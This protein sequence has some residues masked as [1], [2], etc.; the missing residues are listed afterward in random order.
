M[1]PAQST[2]PITLF[3]VGRGSQILGVITTTK[4]W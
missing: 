2:N 3:L 1:V 4:R